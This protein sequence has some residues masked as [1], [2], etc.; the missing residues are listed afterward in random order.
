MLRCFINSF[1]YSSSIIMVLEIFL[2]K[3]ILV[4]RVVRFFCSLY[5]QLKFYNGVTLKLWT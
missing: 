4:D 1:I 5:L 3:M 2:L